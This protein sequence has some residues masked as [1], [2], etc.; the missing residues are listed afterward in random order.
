MD[1]HR[2]WETSND[3]R[4]GTGLSSGTHSLEQILEL[5]VPEGITLVVFAH[6]LAVI[7]IHRLLKVIKDTAENQSWHDGA[8][9]E[10][11][12]RKNG[13]SNDQ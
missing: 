7:G 2:I 6:N 4:Y 3:S 8:T 1:I 9:D 12:P 13:G 10:G 5:Q 11:C